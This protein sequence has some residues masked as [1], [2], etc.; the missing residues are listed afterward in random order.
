MRAFKARRR[1]A[2]DGG[3]GAEGARGAATGSGAGMAAPSAPAV[4]STAAKPQI[5]TVAK[6][7][8]KAIPVTRLI[9]VRGA[10]SKRRRPTVMGLDSYREA[11]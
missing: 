9:S 10:M 11:A 5:T 6:T 1:S 7:I 4:Q 2:S 3:V 8:F